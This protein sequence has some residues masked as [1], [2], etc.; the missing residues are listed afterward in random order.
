MVFRDWWGVAHS[1]CFKVSWPFYPLSSPD[2][3]QPNL[4]CCCHQVFSLPDNVVWP[5]LHYPR[6]QCTQ[7]HSSPSVPMDGVTLSN[8]G[9]HENKSGFFPDSCELAYSRLVLQTAIYY[10]GW[11]GTIPGRALIFLDRKPNLVPTMQYSTTRKNFLQS[12]GRD[13]SL[14][15]FLLEFG[16]PGLLP[17]R[18]K[19]IPQCNKQRR[20]FGAQSKLMVLVAYL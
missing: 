10:F 6:M 19:P 11:T 2:T 7:R 16:T 14:V 3:F 20:S 4:L 12:L 17:W 15:G 18:H 13:G 1:S 8:S 5:H 9:R